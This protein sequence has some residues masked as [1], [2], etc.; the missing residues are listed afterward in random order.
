MTSFILHRHLASQLVKHVNK[1]ASSSFR[2]KC[3]FSSLFLLNW[4]FGL[5]IIYIYIHFSEEWTSIV[6]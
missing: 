2:K 6:H 5:K 3:I 1:W 4:G